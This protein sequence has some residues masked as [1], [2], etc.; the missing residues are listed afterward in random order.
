MEIQIK[1][2]MR[3]YFALIRK[4]I[5]KKTRNKCYRGCGE[6]GTL[7][8]CWCDY[9]LAQPLWKTVWRFLKNVRIKLILLSNDFSQYLS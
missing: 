5:I 9:K 6:N 1:T 8:H 7:T 3:Y 2:I 4:A